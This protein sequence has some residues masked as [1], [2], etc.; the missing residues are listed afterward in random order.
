[1]RFL[2][3]L[4]SVDPRYGGP[5][6]GV[7]SLCLLYRQFG[8]DVEVAT[9]DDPEVIRT[10]SFPAKV[11]GLG[12]GWGVYGYAPRAHHWFQENVHRF[13]VVVLNTI[14][15]YSTLA[16]WRGLSGTK[17]PYAV[18]THGM[19]DPYFRHQFP[20]KH[21]KKCVY[22]ALFLQRIMNG[23]KTVFFTAEEEKLL[24]RKSFR[25]YRVHETVVPYGSFGPYCDLQAARAAFLRQWPELSEKRLLISMGRLHPKKGLDILIEAFSK[26]AAKSQEF[27]LVIAGPD[28]D[29]YRAKLVALAES[30]GVAEKITWTGMLRGDLKWG[31]LSASEVFVLPSHQENFG[32]VVAEALSCSLPVILSNRINIWREVSKHWAG[33]VDEDSVEGTVSSLQ[34]WME[35]TPTEIQALRG[36]ALVCFHRYF[37]LQKSAARLVESVENLAAPGRSPVVQTAD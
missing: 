21:G 15:Q 23:A 8:H 34:R 16:A 32:I 9:L 14:W 28:Q 1:M 10:S 36:R 12:P 19:L 25:G 35:L 4:P 11:T 29:E 26:S 30:L 5:L 18:F 17:V 33:L 31:A 13:D 27:Q 3:V 37:N 20:L 24:A 22:W 2:H 6:E 7:R